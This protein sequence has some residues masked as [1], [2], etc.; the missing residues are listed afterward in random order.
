MLRVVLINLCLLLLPSLIYFAYMYIVKRNG[1][2]AVAQ[3]PILLLFAIGALLMLGSIAY[4]IEF[5]G[6]KPGQRYYPPVI[7][8]GVIQPGHTE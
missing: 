5:H 1:E 6:G 3:A 7:K 8:D 4:F 2:E